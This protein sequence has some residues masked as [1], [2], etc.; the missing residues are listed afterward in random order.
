MRSPVALLCLS[1]AVPVLAA[2]S[3]TATA[4]SCPAHAPGTSVHY[5]TSQ[6]V[7]VANRTSGSRGTWARYEWRGIKK[8]CW[9]K[10]SATSTARSGSGGV[11][12]AARRH[13][14]TNTT[15]AGSFAIKY[16]SVRAIRVRGLPTA[17]SPPA[18]C[19]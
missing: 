1:F 16:A 15:P 18:P 11:V 8:G 7:M 10:V 4:A 12:P 14:N 9:V 13:Q 17:G 2:Q 3:P 6:Q 19:G 5:T